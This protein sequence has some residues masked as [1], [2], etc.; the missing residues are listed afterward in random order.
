MRTN[1]RETW[2]LPDTRDTKEQNRAQEK[3]HWRHGEDTN[4]VKEWEEREK[5]EKETWK[6]TNKRR[7]KQNTTRGRRK[8]KRGL[9]KR[10]EGRRRLRVR[11][12]N[13]DTWTK[14]N[15]RKTKQDTT[16]G[17]RTRRGQKHA[18]WKKKEELGKRT[19]NERK[20]RR[21]KRVTCTLRN[22]KGPNTI[23]AR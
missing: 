1:K 16:H 12:K 17:K 15:K 9:K 2:T 7:T 4:K 22:K 8:T 14:T 11:R 6:L 13:R 19:L 10:G 21:N 23:R 5:K 3:E 18:E 20:E